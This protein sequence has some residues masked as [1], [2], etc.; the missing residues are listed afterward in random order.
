MSAEKD[1]LFR[2]L[3]DAVV[4]LEEE[5]A[6]ELAREVVK[7]NIDAY[8]AVDKGLAH[9]MERAGK[10]FEE[11]EYFVPELLIAAD[12]MYAGLDVLRPHI[13]VDG[14]AEPGKIVLG[15]VEGDTH[16]IGKNLVKIILEA[17]GF[18]VHDLG[19]DVP[20]ASFV[21]KAKEIGAEIIGLSTLMTTTMS[22]MAR[23]V[24]IL[25]ETGLRGQIKV[26]VGGA[27]ISA[28]FARKIG[29]DGYSSDAVGAGDLASRLLEET[30]FSK[31][32]GR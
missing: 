20:P 12:A 32:A 25:R 3:S 11:D 28:A 1:I 7:K 31:R 19:R 17:K 6:A 27:P 2:E 21:S 13:R 29:A 14:G 8:E 9:G 24:E 23:V 16:D 15:V 5:K 26:M 10:L 22:G 30:R 4:F 18:E